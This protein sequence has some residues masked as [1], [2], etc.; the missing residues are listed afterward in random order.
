M[1][2]GAIIGMLF[3]GIVLPK[4]QKDHSGEILLEQT[5]SDIN[6]PIRIIGYLLLG[7]PISAAGFFLLYPTGL[8]VT[9]AFFG[10][11]IGYTTALLLI[12]RKTPRKTGKESNENLPFLLELGVGLL[13]SLV[14]FGVF[15][16]VVGRFFVRILPSLFRIWWSALLILIYLLCFTLHAKWM[17]LI[18]FNKQQREFAKI[19]S[20]INRLWFYIKGTAMQTG[21]QLICIIG[22]F[23]IQLIFI[24][25]LFPLMFMVSM[26]GIL[27]LMNFIN[28]IWRY[29]RNSMVLSIGL[30]LFPIVWMFLSLSPLVG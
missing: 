15:N 20:I 27:I 10:P 17:D 13:L 29:W 11:I 12:M 22:S 26:I 16:L 5:G 6:S 23:L 8:L 2:V 30:F 3:L 21:V 7:I 19:T 25:N 24:D 18:Y 14:L 28:T 4:I 1:L 9:A